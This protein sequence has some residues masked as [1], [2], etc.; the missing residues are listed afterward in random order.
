MILCGDIITG[1]FV[2]EQLFVRSLFI[3]KEIV[4]HGRVIS[5]RLSFLFVLFMC[6]FALPL[7]AQLAAAK[8]GRS[9]LETECLISAG[10]L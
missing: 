6:A 1:L 8:T 5:S 7:K 9:C 4:G 2:R 10:G 3:L